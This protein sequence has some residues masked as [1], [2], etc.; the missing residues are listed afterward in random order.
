MNISRRFRDD[1]RVQIQVD[2]CNIR[3]VLLVPIPHR[4]ELLEQPQLPV[5]PGGVTARLH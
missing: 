2:L 5:R 1:A 3:G 4:E